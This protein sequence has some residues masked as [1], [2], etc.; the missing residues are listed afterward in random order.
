MATPVFPIVLSKNNV[1]QFQLPL[2][3]YNT[4]VTFQCFI[5]ILNK[6]RIYHF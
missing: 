1:W 2:G 5:V 3:W 6:D 4:I